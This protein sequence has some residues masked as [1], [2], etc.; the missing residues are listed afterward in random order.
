MA[1]QHRKTVH[2]TGGLLT[3]GPKFS[4]NYSDYQ[5]QRT[6]SDALSAA[7][8]YTT[9][10][11]EQRARKENMQPIPRNTMSRQIEQQLKKKY[12]KK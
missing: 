11:A 8:G 2:A 3:G 6:V 5:K 12:P 10:P 4:S 1:R 9:K 7:R